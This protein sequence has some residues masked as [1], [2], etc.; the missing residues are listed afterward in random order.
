MV[1]FDM[2]LEATVEWEKADPD[3]FSHIWAYSRFDSKG[4]LS[5][6]E[7]E[8]ISPGAVLNPEERQRYAIPEKEIIY[9]CAKPPT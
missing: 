5:P 8:E 7:Y 4:K 2:S 6:F 1:P 3:V 9:R